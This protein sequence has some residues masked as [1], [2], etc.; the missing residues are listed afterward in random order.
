[1]ASIT[2]SAEAEPVA[3][4]GILS[5]R[6]NVGREDAISIFGG[7]DLGAMLWR[8]RKGGLQAVADVYV[9]YRFYRVHIAGRRASL[10]HIYA[11]DSVD[12][13]LDPYE[14]ETVP[15][16]QSLMQVKTRN[17]L[18]ASLDQEQAKS[19]LREKTLRMIFQGGFFK[20]GTADLRLESLGAEIYLP[21]WL[22]F[23]GRNG[24]VGFR[25]I[26]AVRR[27]VEGAKAH[28]LFESWIASA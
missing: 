9:P 28:A 4:R 3:A 26:D 6:P 27:R 20:V 15:A 16:G 2:T 22:G 24:R 10:T 11:I 13:S 21:Y 5:V 23:Y 7:R 12:G 1:L 17:C 25:I 19:L 18:A 14:F 8:L